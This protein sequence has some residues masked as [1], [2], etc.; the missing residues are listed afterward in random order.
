MVYCQFWSDYQ[1]LIS[2]N[3]N[4]KLTIIILLPAF[5]ISFIFPLI[6]GRKY[7]RWREDET[8][9]IQNNFKSYIEGEEPKKYPG[10][11]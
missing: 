9:L 4:G 3:K 11:L 2:K 7:T 8:L 6:T 5:S 10:N 1:D